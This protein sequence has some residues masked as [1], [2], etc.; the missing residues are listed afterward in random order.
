MKEEPQ[1]DVRSDHWKIV[2]DILRKNVPQF[3]VW[4]F[5]SRAQWKAKKFSDLDLA[6]ITEKP[7]PIS[8]LAELGDD[9]SRSDVPYKVDVVDWAA[10]S[11]SFRRIIEQD[12]VVVQYLAPE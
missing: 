5:G 12:K 7:L 6:V 11:E 10:A 9:F 1:I 2:R 4:A 3:E 8:T